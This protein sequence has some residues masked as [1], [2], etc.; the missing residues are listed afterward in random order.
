VI[1]PLE[2]K[3][4]AFSIDFWPP[5]VVVHNSQYGARDRL[6]ELLLY[7]SIFS[8]RRHNPFEFC[9]VGKAHRL[10]CHAFGSGEGIFAGQIQKW[11]S[12]RGYFFAKK[13]FALKNI[14]P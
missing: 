6:L 4:L 5:S 3:T 2:N 14:E 9:R 7:F 13:T 10:L 12:H 8:E 11:Q 1:W